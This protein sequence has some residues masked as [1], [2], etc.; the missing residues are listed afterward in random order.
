MRGNENLALE[1][2]DIEQSGP[3]LLARI[4]SL[5]SQTIGKLNLSKM[6]PAGQQDK[7]TL[8]GWNMYNTGGGG[9]GPVTRSTLDGWPG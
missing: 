9:R 1:S 7:I 3:R 4:S 6:W 5:P 2:A 8:E